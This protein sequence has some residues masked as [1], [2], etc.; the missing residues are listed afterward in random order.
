MGSTKQKS[1]DID[2]GARAHLTFIIIADD[3]CHYFIPTGGDKPPETA[4]QMSLLELKVKKLR[5]GGL[6]HNIVTRRFLTS[7]ARWKRDHI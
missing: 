3:K 2:K 4:G 5:C 1:Q 6:F 7:E